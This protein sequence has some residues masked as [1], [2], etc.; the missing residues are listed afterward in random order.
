MAQKINHTNSLR[1]AHKVC[2]SILKLF[3]ERVFYGKDYFNHFFNFVSWPDNLAI[4]FT[5]SQ[6]QAFAESRENCSTCFS[7]HD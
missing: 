7:G 5:A 1:L 4:C 6:Y 3:F 2:L